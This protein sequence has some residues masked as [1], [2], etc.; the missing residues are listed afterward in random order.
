MLRVRDECHSYSM[1]RAAATERTQGT[2]PARHRAR[3]VRRLV[4]ELALAGY[5][6][7]RRRGALGG[8]R[9]PDLYVLPREAR[10]PVTDAEMSALVESASKP[11]I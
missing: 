6:G 1:G 7:H 9:A 3:Q 4:K 5:L 2:A 11:D 8:R 10:Q